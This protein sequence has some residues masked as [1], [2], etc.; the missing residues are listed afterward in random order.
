VISPAPRAEASVRAS[1]P[2]WTPAT[3]PHVPRV[4]R[5]R[6]RLASGAIVD[7]VTV[8]PIGAECPFA[9]VYCDLWQHTLGPVPSAPGSLPRQ[10][11]RGLAAVG[12]A[13]EQVKVYNGSNF[14]EE[15]A[16]PAADDGALLEVLVP[17]PRVVVECHPRW[18]GERCFRFAARLAGRLQVAIGLETVHPEALPRLGKAMTVERFD[19]AVDALLRQGIGARAFVLV[20][21]PFVPSAET[22]EWTVRSVEHALRRGVEHVSLLPVR[23]GNGA[24]DEARRRGE[25]RPPTLGELEDAFDASSSLGVPGV[26]TVDLWDLDEGLTCLACR[27]PRRQRLERMN[28]GGAVEPRVACSRGCTP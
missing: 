21:A 4:L 14:F 12:A 23:G 2:P 1:R 16:V 20:G 10:L 5:E 24:V 7:S 15:R 25:L 28:L 27:D 17:F 19:R 8:F 6:E 18:I 13:A 3:V 22:V 11:R 9:C 26:V